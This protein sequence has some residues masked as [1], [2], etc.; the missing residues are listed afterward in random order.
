MEGGRPCAASANSA[1]WCHPWRRTDDTPI[2]LRGSLNVPLT[3]TASVSVNLAA[4]VAGERRGP[5]LSIEAKWRLLR[6]PSF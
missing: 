2:N 4:A 3:V 1:R 6:S 5:V